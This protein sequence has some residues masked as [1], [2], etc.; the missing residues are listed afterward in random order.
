V[1]DSFKLMYIGKNAKGDLL[2]YCSFHSQRCTDAKSLQVPISQEAI[3]LTELQEKIIEMD[4][5]SE[6]S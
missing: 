3:A 4:M 5:L 2:T 6:I 1:F